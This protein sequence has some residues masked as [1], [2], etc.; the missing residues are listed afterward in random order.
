MLRINIISFP[1][2]SSWRACPPSPDKNEIP[3]FDKMPKQVRHNGKKFQM[4]NRL[5]LFFRIKNFFIT[6]L[7]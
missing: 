3:K 5:L 7:S 4:H 1:L 6:K 2:L